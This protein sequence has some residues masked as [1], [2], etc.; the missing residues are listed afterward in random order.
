MEDYFENIDARINNK[1]SS[2]IKQGMNLV[3][4]KIDFLIES[5]VDLILDGKLSPFE[6]NIMN[7][8]N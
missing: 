3:L 5:K 7:M 4:T 6:A 2:G 8:V 1:I